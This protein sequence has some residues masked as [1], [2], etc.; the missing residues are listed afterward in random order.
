MEQQSTFDQVR[1]TTTNPFPEDRDIPA[2]EICTKNISTL[3]CPSDSW[4]NAPTITGSGLNHPGAAGNIMLCYGDG[5]N[6]LHSDDSGGGDGDVSS[7]GM[8]YYSAGKNMSSCTDGTSNTILISES[9]VPSGIGTKTVKGGIA[10][11]GGI[12]VGY[13][14]WSPSVCMAIRNGQEFSG[15]AHVSWRAARYLDGVVL[16]TGFNTI[17][18][19]NS[20]SCVKDS[21]EL[22]SG[23]YAANSNHSGG[24]NCGRVDG[25]VS[26]VSDTVDT[27]GLPDSVQGKILT[28]SSPYG[29]WGAMG[30]PDGGESKAL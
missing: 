30:T 17:M 16:Y 21:S 8:F 11:L 7:R 22:T 27:G 28:G 26:F 1:A 19:P 14:T 3:R 10:V 9:C 2:A 4:G 15:T 6:R 20:P 18:P 5:A 25:S 29:V 12:D 24:V 23:L 13:W